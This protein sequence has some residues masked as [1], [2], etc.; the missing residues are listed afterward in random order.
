MSGKLSYEITMAHPGDAVPICEVLAQTWLDTYPNA[1]NGVT[2]EM[3][4]AFHYEPDGRLNREHVTKTE[5]GILESSP[6]GKH[7]IFTASFE[8]KVVGVSS[9]III[10]E[11]KRKLNVVYVLPQYQG[12]GIGKDLIEPVLQWHGNKDVYLKVASFNKRAMNLYE[13]Y[14]FIVSGPVPED[15]QFVFANGLVLPEVEMV[16]QP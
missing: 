13:K 3:I 16:R 9:A 1:E 12:K 15:E 2:V 4:Q 10:K 11:S 6:D 14:G 7:C 8:D 5:K